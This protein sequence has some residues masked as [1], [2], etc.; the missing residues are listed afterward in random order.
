MVCGLSAGLELKSSCVCDLG[1]NTVATKLVRIWT[2]IN[3]FLKHG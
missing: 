1:V 3:V 2:A